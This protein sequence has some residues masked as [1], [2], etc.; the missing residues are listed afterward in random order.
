[1][2]SSP[3]TELKT[4]PSEGELG[5]AWSDIDRVFGPYDNGKVFTP[6]WDLFERN[7]DRMLDLDGKARALEQVLT[8]PLTWAPYS[9]KPAE[10]DRGEAEFVKEWLFRP[11]EQGGMSTP[12]EL[13]VAQMSSA[14]LYRRAFF[15]LV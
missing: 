13:V 2:P 15:E 1:M 3:G 4:R 9:V 14:V 6:V 11:A 8:L 7:I 12:L 10:G 5:S